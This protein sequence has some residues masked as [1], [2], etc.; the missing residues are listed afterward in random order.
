MSPWSS[1]IVVVPKRSTPGEPPQ[2]HLCID[3]QAINRLLPPIVKVN[4]KAQGVPIPHLSTK[5]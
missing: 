4:S 1:P 2:K 3:Y 5:N